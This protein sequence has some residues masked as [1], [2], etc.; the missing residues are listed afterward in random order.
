MELR[1]KLLLLTMLLLHHSVVAVVTER[2]A[3][4]FHTG[5]MKISNTTRGR[6][7]KATT[8]T[9]APASRTKFTK[10]IMEFLLCLEF[11]VRIFSKGILTPWKPRIIIEKDP[12][13]RID[14]IPGLP[15]VLPCIMITVCTMTAAGVSPRV[16]PCR[17]RLGGLPHTY[18][19]IGLGCE[20]KTR[21]YLVR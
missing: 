11:P 12:R 21:Q 14:P 20:Y 6:T 18:E 19:I 4:K 5:I 1:L 8:N 16:G 7:A 10:G 3:W 9:V 17:I 13:F 15:R 2:R